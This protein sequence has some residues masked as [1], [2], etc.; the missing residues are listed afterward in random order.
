MKDLIAHVLSPYRVVRVYG[1]TY[2]VKQ[3][4]SWELQGESQSLEES[5]IKRHRFDHLLRRNQVEPILQRLGFAV[6]TVP[7]LSERIKSLK[8]DLYRKFPDMIAQ[9]PYRSQLQGGKKELLALHSE[10]GSLDT[11]TLEFFAEKMAAFHVIKKTLV[12]CPKD[13]RQD[14]TF[15]EQVYYAL[16][17]NTVSVERLRGLARNDFWRSVWAS[18]KTHTF[19]YFPLTEEQMALA[20]FSRMYDNILNHN[21]PPPQPVID[22]DDML[23]GWMLLQQEERNKKKQPTYGHK[24]D[25]AKEVF[26]M[27]QNQHHADNIYDMNNPEQRAIQRVRQ[28]QLGIQGRVQ[29]GQFMDVQRDIQNATR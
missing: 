18:R 7:E 29:L 5:L 28:K 4:V 25:S 2:K 8:K 1:K 9:R 26:V 17:R 19:R 12:K 13:Y 24:I 6:D 10:I 22:D 27:A 15:L 23:D 3:N 16:L 21:D 11:H 14:F 20:S